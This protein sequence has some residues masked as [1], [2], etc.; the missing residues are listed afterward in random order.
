MCKT[1][2]CNRTSKKNNYDFLRLLPNIKIAG[3]KKNISKRQE[4]FNCHKT[5]NFNCHKTEFVDCRTKNSLMS[6]FSFHNYFNMS[7]LKRELLRA[8]KSNFNNF[9]KIN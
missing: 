6:P 8:L 9:M 3:E 4:N 5:E 1:K 7:D 2:Y